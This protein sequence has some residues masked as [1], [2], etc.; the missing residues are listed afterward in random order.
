MAVGSCISV[1]VVPCMYDHCCTLACWVDACLFPA[2]VHSF[3][4]TRGLGKTL[5]VERDEDNTQDH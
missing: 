3:G 4:L 1:L 5:E 2:L